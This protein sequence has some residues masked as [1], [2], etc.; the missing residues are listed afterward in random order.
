[1]L[2]YHPE[3]WKDVEACFTT[4]REARPRSAREFGAELLALIEHIREFPS[5]GVEVRKHVRRTML[6]RFHYLVYYR[7][8]SDG[9]ELLGLVHG[10]RD[11]A[12]WLGD[13]LRA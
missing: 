11:V 9:I 13:R 8:R 4:L 7:A 6:R 12:K 10:M 1:M 3:F 2:R 5:A